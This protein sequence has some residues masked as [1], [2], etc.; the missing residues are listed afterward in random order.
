MFSIFHQGYLFGCFS[1]FVSSDSRGGN[2]VFSLTPMSFC[3]GSEVKNLPAM[4]ETQ[5]TGLWSLGWENPL[6]EKMATH[7]SMLARKISRTGY[8]SE[9]QSMRSQRV[10]HN[11]VCIQQHNC[12]FYSPLSKSRPNVTVW[13]F[14]KNNQ[15][16]IV[17]KW[18]HC[19]LT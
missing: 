7:S 15:T 3:S 11:W 12:W 6:E 17:E 1:S 4:Q 10:G 9:L 8:P 2:F 14:P 16:T 5:E 13:F 19:S 18:H